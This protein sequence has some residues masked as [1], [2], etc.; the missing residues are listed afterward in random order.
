MTTEEESPLHGP[1][2]PDGG[3]LHAAAGQ[4]HEMFGVHRQLDQVLHESAKRVG[5]V[6]FESIFTPISSAVIAKR[7]RM[8]AIKVLALDHPMPQPVVACLRQSRMQLH[9][10]CADAIPIS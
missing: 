10:A 9:R 7:P 6:E 4:L 1:P 2:R 5:G 8:D 3:L